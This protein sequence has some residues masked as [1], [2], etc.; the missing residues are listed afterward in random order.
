LS[1]G[2]MLDEIVVTGNGINKNAK[3]L[4]YGVSSVGKDY[5]RKK[6]EIRKSISVKP[7][8]SLNV[9]SFEIVSPYTIPSN[10]E[11]YDVLLN[12]NAIPF[13]YEYIAYPSKEPTAYLGV[14]IPA[15]RNYDL[16]SGKVNLFLEGQYTGVSKL[17]I[18]AKTDTLWF[19]LGEDIGV[20]IE[21]EL[22]EE[23]NKK[24]FFKNKT[25]E[26][27]TFDIIVKNNKNKTIEIDL[28][29]Q[30]PISTDDDIKVKVLEISE[31]IYEKKQGYLT[32]K[33]SLAPGESRK[34]RV[35]YEIK[36]GENVDIVSN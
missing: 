24:S 3:T 12:S 10:G 22:V 7:Q 1:E 25:I 16:F 4:G 19:S 8:Q 28:H 2:T 11:E 13:E 17:D 36:Y 5:K 34:Y 21:K 20:H 27:H 32:W 14:G 26:L 23:Y 15:W 35:S 31:A 33:E 29:D 9:H 30:V 18:S 6:V